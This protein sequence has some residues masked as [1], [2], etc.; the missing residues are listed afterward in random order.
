ML[1]FNTLRSLRIT[2]RTPRLE[3]FILLRQLLL[4]NMNLNLKINN[5]YNLD[6]L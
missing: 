4:K 5:E 3:D 2:L 6:Y 1:K